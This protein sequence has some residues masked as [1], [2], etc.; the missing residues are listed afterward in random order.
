MGKVKVAAIGVSVDGFAAGPDQSLENPGGT[1]VQNFLG[2]FF[3]RR[4]SRI[5][6]RRMAVR[7]AW[8]TN[9][10]RDPS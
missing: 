9:L 1:G 4:Y 3:R 6:M 10:P 8:T 5:C 2:G 7:P